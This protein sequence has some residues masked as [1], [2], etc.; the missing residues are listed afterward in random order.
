MRAEM[1]G[2]KDDYFAAQGG[3]V[4]V[5]GLFRDTRAGEGEGCS[6]RDRPGLEGPICLPYSRT[7]MLTFRLGS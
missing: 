6:H 5:A 7:G 1:S 4:A 3:G 2:G